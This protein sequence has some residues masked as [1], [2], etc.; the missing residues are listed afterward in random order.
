[1]FN[2][3]TDRET[4]EWSN[5]WIENAGSSA[6]KRILIIGDSVARN[7]RGSISKLKI[8]KLRK[9]LQNTSYPN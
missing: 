6:S 8:K 9:K 5:I 7:F 2:Y 4:I 1:M 3:Q